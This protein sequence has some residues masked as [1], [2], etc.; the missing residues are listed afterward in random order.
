VTGSKFRTE[1]LQTLGATVQNVFVRAPCISSP[2]VCSV[3]FSKTSTPALG[4][5]RSPN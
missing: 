3:I 4:L 5:T 1:G 2:P